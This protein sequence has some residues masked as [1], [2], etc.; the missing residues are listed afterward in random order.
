MKHNIWYNIPFEPEEDIRYVSDP[1]L[2]DGSLIIVEEGDLQ[3]RGTVRDG[4]I[5]WIDVPPVFLKDNLIPYTSI[6]TDGSN[7]SLTLFF[8]YSD[9]FTADEIVFAPAEANEAAS[10][11]AKKAT[12]YSAGDLISFGHYEQDNDFSNG[13]EAIEWIVLD[14]KDDQALLISRYGL[15]VQPFHTEWEDVTWEDCTL[16]SWLNHDFLEGAFTPEERGTVL[17]TSVDNSQSQGS[18][19]GDAVSENN[20]VDRVFLLSYAEAEK[21][22]NSNQSRQCEATPYAA[23]KAT[24][25]YA[26]HTYERS[27]NYRWWWL[28]TSSLGIYS[29]DLA[30][31]DGYLGYIDSVDSDSPLVRPALWVDLNSGLF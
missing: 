5:E 13:D 30:G 6:E 24:D 11:P 4:E 26:P 21:Y 14:L 3:L 2:S 10:T 12:T 17:M 22:L 18:G 19:E 28:R 9:Y 16:R 15:D 23:S 1:Q 25:H 29:V 20:T 27:G 31:A 7:I 8:I